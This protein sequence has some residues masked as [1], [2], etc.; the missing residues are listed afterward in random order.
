MEPLK[1]GNLRWDVRKSEELSG[2]GPN[3]FA[4]RNVQLLPSGD[5]RLEVTRR[6]GVWTCAELQTQERLGLGVYQFW[7]VGRPDL[8]DPLLVFGFSPYPTPD[9]GPDGTHEIDIEFAR[10]GDKAKPC[11]NFTVCPKVPI[12]WSSP[13][14]TATDSDAMSAG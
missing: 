9:I 11:G 8:L 13:A 2:P 12:S 3:I 10:W 1:F 5:L 14:T 7:L 4:P 6:D